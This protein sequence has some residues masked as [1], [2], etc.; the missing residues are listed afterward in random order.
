MVIENF[1]NR[2]LYH[3]DNLDVLRGLNS[4]TF[5]LI[6]TDPPF[7]K[8]RDFYATPDSLAAGAKFTDRWSWDRD[9]HQE[10][11]DLIKDDWS[12]VYEVIDA[13][14]VSYGMDMAAF[15][16]WLGVRLLE[17]HRVLKSTGS[18]YLHIDHTAHAYVKVLLDAIFGAKNFR[19]AITW[20]RTTRAH[21]NASRRWGNTTDVLLYYT[22]GGAHCYNIQYGAINV[23]EYRLE[24]DD[25][26]GPYKLIAIG[27]PGYRPNSE[28][29]QAWRGMMPASGRCWATPTTGRMDCGWRNLGMCLGGRILGERVG[30]ML[31]WML[32]IWPA[33]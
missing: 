10:W 14:K 8:G 22:K 24:D 23:K 30:F 21:S 2:T 31:G 5:D 9:V 4:D 26:R 20:K 12:A 19:N 3:H 11:V 6:A 25:A 16:C 33:W 1:V 27:A 17:C 7:N 15:L 29:G 18:F 13:A 32:Y 28:K